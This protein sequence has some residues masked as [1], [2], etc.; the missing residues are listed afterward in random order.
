ML[1]FLK[2]FARGIIVTILL[3]IILLVLALYFVYCLL[4]FIFMFFK[5]S[6]DFFKGRTLDTDLPEDLE[7]KRIVLE[8]EKADHQAKEMLNMMYQTTMAQAGF[9]QSTQ[10][11]DGMDYLEKST[12]EEAVSQYDDNGEDE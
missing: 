1:S 2:V 4:L 8:K 10:Q 5:G 9:N 12:T 6:I 3:P 11:S 7:A